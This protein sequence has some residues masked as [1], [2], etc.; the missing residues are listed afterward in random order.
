MPQ[1]RGVHSL[2]GP[3]LPQTSWNIFR[4][5][6]TPSGAPVAVVN[7]LPVSCQLD[8]AASRSAAWST[9]H[10]LSAPAAIYASSS[11][12][13]DL[14][15]FVSPPG[16][17]RTQRRDRRRIAV[18]IDVLLPPDRPGLP[19]GARQRSG[20]QRCR[21]A[22]TTPD[23]ADPSAC[24]PPQC[25]RCLPLRGTPVVEG[26]AAMAAAHPPQA[27]SMHWWF[28]AM[29]PESPISVPKRPSSCTNLVGAGGF[30]PPLLACKAQSL[31]CVTS[32]GVA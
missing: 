31:R 19:R 24:V 3:A 7:T 20:S 29:V 11:A 32:L 28:P 12:R 2:P 9:C 8:Q 4:I 21:H 30:E 5:C 1:V 17:I 22:S 13:R 23:A 18:Q 15:A 26:D 10:S 14:R 6:L 27:D 25:R 16:P